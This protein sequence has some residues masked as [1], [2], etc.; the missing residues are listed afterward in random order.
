MVKILIFCLLLRAE[1]STLFLP[2]SDTAALVA[3]VS[4]TSSTVAHTLELLNVAKD[5]R[6]RI[7]H[8]NNLATRRL[9]LARRLEQHARDMA[10][11]KKMRPQN[12]KEFNHALSSLKSNLMS[13]ESSLDSMG[14]ETVQAQKVAGDY[15]RKRQ[16]ALG[17]EREV[18]LQE[19]SS[20]GAGKSS[21]H[22][23]NTAMNTALNGK[24]LSKIRRDQL[25]YQQALLGLKKGEAVE[26]L[27][28]DEFYKNWMRIRG[29]H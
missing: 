29:K 23:Q 19:I 24:I 22:I 7:E 12:L 14:K 17:D 4:N 26:K 25:D 8:F 13:L 1:A 16:N 21:Y 9:Y 20:A 3:L 2:D 10:A 5:T 15:E 11:I 28:Q 18:Q 27:R 6:E